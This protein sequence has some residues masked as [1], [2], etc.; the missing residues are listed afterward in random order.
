MLRQR[1][2][3]V[4]HQ[5]DA[6]SAAKLLTRRCHQQQVAPNFAASLPKRKAALFQAALVTPSALS[7]FVGYGL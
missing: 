6:G 2:R 4:G 3:T 1:F 7:F 5:L